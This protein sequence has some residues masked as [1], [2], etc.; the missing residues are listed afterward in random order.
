MQSLCRH[1]MNHEMDAKYCNWTGNIHDLAKHIKVCPYQAIQCK[2]CRDWILREDTN[3]HYSICSRFPIKCNE[4]NLKIPRCLLLNHVNEQC[5]SSKIKCKKCD[6][7]IVRKDKAYHLKNECSDNLI[8][9]KFHKFGCSQLIKQNTM[10]SHLQQNIDYHLQLL[11]TEM[12]I[13][14]D[15]ETA[16]Y[17]RLY[18]KLTKEKRT[19]RKWFIDSL[20]NRLNK[21]QHFPFNL[22]FENNALKEIEFGFNAINLQQ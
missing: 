12:S 13:N 22:N 14:G 20:S 19:S 9:C 2:H 17:H 8:P 16:K 15:G 4:C 3:N 21:L 10:Q 18:E 6:K 11:Q 1:S 5:K 7:I